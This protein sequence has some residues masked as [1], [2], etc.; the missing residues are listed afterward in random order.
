MNKFYIG[1]IKVI[2]NEEHLDIL[3]YNKLK[4]EHTQFQYHAHI[5]FKSLY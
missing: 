2:G 4:S 1:E 3:A 5:K